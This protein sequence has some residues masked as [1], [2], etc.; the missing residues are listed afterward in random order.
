[1]GKELEPQVL[2][3]HLGFRAPSPAPPSR[4]CSE[5]RLQLLA[6]RHQSPARVQ[7]RDAGFSRDAT[8][9]VHRHHVLLEPPQQTRLLA[10]GTVAPSTLDT[11]QAWRSARP[12]PWASI[13][14]ALAV[15]SPGWGPV[16]IPAL[17]SD[18][19]GSPRG[20]LA[21]GVGGRR[22]GRDSETENDPVTSRLSLQRWRGGS[23]TVKFQCLGV[24][25][26][27]VLFFCPCGRTTQP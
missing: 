11:S 2:G 16:C 4:L 1:M 25:R 20:T 5:P 27:R 22:Q 21:R 7:T 23:S 26:N 14:A 24:R 15:P 6:S 17:S 18:R 3:V 8:Y 13:D 10:C 9:G 12:P 19:E